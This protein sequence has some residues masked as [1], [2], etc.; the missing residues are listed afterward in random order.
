MA[1]ETEYDIEKIRALITRARVVLW[2]FDGPI[3]ML[4]AG[5]PSDRV[6]AGFVRWLDQLGL[7]DLLTDEERTYTDPQAVLRAID[8]RHPGSDLVMAMEKRLTQEEFKAVTSAMPTPFADPLIRTW[9]AL[10]SRLAITTNN[11]PEV[12]HRY[13]GTRGLLS[14]FAPH[15]YGR[16]QDLGLLKP[17]PHCLNRALSATGADPSDALMIGDAPSDF[18]AAQEAGVAFLGYARN[19]KKEEDLKQAGVESVVGSL[20]P[21]LTLLW[22]RST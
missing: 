8:G 15:I 20:E 9:K 19:P 1:A 18:D 4:F 12:V 3:C 11:S 14:C 17:D 16:T 6:A 7:S 2:D 21:L 22:E 5:H 10:G 13:L